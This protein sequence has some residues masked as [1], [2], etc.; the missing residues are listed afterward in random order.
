M[1]AALMRM[2]VKDNVKYDRIFVSAHLDDAVWSN[3]GQMVEAVKA[4]EAVLLLN[5]FT[6]FKSDGEVRP[7]TRGLR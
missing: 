6:G 4:G 7:A 2:A 5:L 3:G 1:E